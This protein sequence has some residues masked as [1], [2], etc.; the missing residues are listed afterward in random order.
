V[1]AEKHILYFVWFIVCVVPQVW[2]ELTFLALNPLQ[3]P[4]EQILSLSMMRCAWSVQQTYYVTWLLN[5]G[6]RDWGK[7][8]YSVHSWSFVFGR[9]EGLSL[10]AENSA[11]TWNVT[12]PFDWESNVVPWDS[13]FPSCYYT[14]KTS[15]LTDWLMQH[16]SNDMLVRCHFCVTVSKKCIFSVL[17]YLAQ[18]APP[19]PPNFSA[20]LCGILIKGHVSRW[21]FVWNVRMTHYVRM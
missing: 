14:S 5:H 21:L 9:L 1:K 17:Q 13:W 10:W 6:R 4:T 20:W 3:G 15:F 12:K 19:P 18:S 7:A 8:W 11:M 2:S 16:F